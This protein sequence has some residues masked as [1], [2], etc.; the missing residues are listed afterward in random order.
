MELASITRQIPKHNILVIGCYFNAHLG[1]LNNSKFSYH[2][3]ANR[4]GNMLHNFINEN[5]LICLNTHFQKKVG[6]LWT[7]KAPNKIYK[8]I[9]QLD[10]VLINKKW[11]NSVKNCRAYNSFI[12]VAS[13]HR[14]V[15]ANIQLALR[16]NKNKSS[17][18]KPYDWSN[19]NNK[20]DIRNKF[21]IEVKNR[22]EA[23]QNDEETISANTAYTYFET[24]CKESSAKY[25]PLYTIKVKTEEKD[26]MGN[27]EIC[28]K[29]KDLHIAA[30]LKDSQISFENQKK[31]NKTIKELTSA[32]D[33]ERSKYVNKKIKDIEIAAA[34]KQSSIAL[35]IVNEISGRK[36]S[37]SAK[38]KAS[39]NG[40]RIQIWHNQTNDDDEEILQIHNKVNIKIGLF[41]IQE[42]N[43][44]T[45]SINNGKACGV[46][47]IPAEVWKLTEFQIILLNFCNSV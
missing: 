42:L 29:R 10:Y 33:A 12:S 19:L 39:S 27:H 34:N 5:N 17:R 26:A 7:H 40:E 45:K 18:I 3:N 2:T 31:F 46:D 14:I 16:A 13:D 30:K 9:A 43:N 36:K 35:K 25:I 20:A 23:L 4:N 22:F 28:Q 44:A 47:E 38:L 21:I 11:K 6:Q 32:Y 15:T 37:N 1:I 24:A 41:T 8:S